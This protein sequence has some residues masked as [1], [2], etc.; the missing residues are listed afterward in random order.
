MNYDILYIGLGLIIGLLWA[1][2]STIIE[3]KNLLKKEGN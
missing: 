2:T 3:I 1:I